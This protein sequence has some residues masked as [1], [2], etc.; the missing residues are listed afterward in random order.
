MAEIPIYTFVSRADDA[1]Q[2]TKAET[3][4]YE[5]GLSRESSALQ[6]AFLSTG[7]CENHQRYLDIRV[8]RNPRDILS[9]VNRINALL[10]RQDGDACFGALVDL[11]IALGANGYALRKSLLART[12]AILSEPQ[13]IFLY[14][15]LESGLKP[16]DNIA[17]NRDSLLSDQ[18]LGTVEFVRRSDSPSNDGATLFEQALCAR[19]SGEW[20]TT[21]RFLERL[22]FK[23]PGNTE[24]SMELL[25]LY[26][27][28][29]MKTAFQ[30]TYAQLIGRQFA[31]PNLWEKLNRR[32]TNNS[33]Q[34]MDTTQ[35]QP[36][37]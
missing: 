17:G 22:V 21:R 31:R 29:E 5:P 13:Q 12:H 24:A 6:Q 8:A 1:N 32:F 19:A 25:S 4:A 3:E 34:E 9:H 16:T 28:R 37:N 2:E 23:D 30:S 36:I 15:H 27:E 14:Q 18:V 26:Q 7:A 20:N 33:G 35:C 10:E 11:N